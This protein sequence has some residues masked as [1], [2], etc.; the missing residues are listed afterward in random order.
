[1]KACRAI[2]ELQSDPRVLV[3]KDSK[4]TSRM[5]TSGFSEVS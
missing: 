1:M 5:D 4:G 2:L 3:K